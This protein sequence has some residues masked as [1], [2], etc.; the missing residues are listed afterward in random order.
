MR[1]WTVELRKHLHFFAFSLL[2][3]VLALGFERWANNPVSG[4]TWVFAVILI[5]CAAAVYVAMHL[6]NY[7]VRDHDLLFH[8]STQSPA[9]KFTLKVLPLLL[10]TVAI[11][12]TT[13]TGYALTSNQAEAQLASVAFLYAGKLLSLAA[14][15]TLV[16]VLCRIARLG[17]GLTTQLLIFGILFVGLITCEIIVFWNIYSLDSNAWSVGSSSEFLGIPMYMNTLPIA[18]GLDG[19]WTVTNPM[20]A[21]LV[22]NLATIVICTL[23][24]VFVLRSRRAGST[25]HADLNVPRSPVV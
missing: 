16:W 18:V 15:V 20:V 13:V 8:M 5:S 2:L 14:F 24:E 17:R 1:E 11:G 6:F 4:V 10:G 9:K 7:I 19:S 3:L 21:S 12:L 22:V 23:L 25:S